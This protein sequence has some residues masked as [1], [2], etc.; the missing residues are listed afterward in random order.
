MAKIIN[1]RQAKKVRNRAKN[2]AEGTEN[3]ARFGRSKAQQSL[4]SARLEK[5][6]AG[7]DG[8]KREPEE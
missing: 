7:L 8:H 4:E 6:Q 3:A 1:L 5:E 2:R